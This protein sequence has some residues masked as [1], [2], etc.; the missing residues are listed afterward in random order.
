MMK[1]EVKQEKV[2]ELQKRLY[3]VQQTYFALQKELSEKE[4][5]ATGEI[6]NKMGT[7]LQTMGRDQ[8]YTII[9]EKSAVLY[10]KNHIDLTNEPIRRYNDAYGS[11]K[12]KK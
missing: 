1:P 7:L 4:S 9:I 3:E 8:G 2:A 12:K 11:K 6:F 5:K 10:A